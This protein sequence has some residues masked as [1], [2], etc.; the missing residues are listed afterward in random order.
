MTF[1]CKDLDLIVNIPFLVFN[2]KSVV[3]KLLETSEKALFIAE[4][5]TVINYL[6]QIH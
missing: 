1:I 3:F 5:L 4:F 6:M 2:V